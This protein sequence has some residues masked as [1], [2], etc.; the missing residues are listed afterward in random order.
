M[1]SAIR[2]VANM[3]DVS[4][5]TAENAADRLLFK[6]AAAAM[7]SSDDAAH[8]YTHCFAYLESLVPGSI[9]VKRLRTRY[10]SQLSAE[11]A[12]V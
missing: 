2:L 6:T 3:A 11:A 1:N 4:D 8:P 12:R 10:A 9:A 7:A 5:G